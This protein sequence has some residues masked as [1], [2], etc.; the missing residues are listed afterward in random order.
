MWIGDWDCGFGWEIR[1]VDSDG[2]LGFGSWIGDGIKI[3][4]W[5]LVIGNL[6]LDGIGIGNGVWGF[7]LGIELGIVD[8][9][10]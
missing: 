10:L 2:S 3:G 9:R 5:E 8:L 7:G 4:D 6:G 1:I